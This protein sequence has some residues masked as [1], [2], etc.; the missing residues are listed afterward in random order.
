MDDNFLED[1]FDLSNLRYSSADKVNEFVNHINSIDI[2]VLTS[3]NLIIII[4][5]G[6]TISMKIEN[7]VSIPDLDCEKIIEVGVSHLRDKF[8]VESFELFS[9]DSSQM[10][11]S[12]ISEIAIV[13]SY[14][15]SK[16]NS[17]IFL[18]FVLFHGTDTMSYS[19][20]ALSLILGRGL[21]FSVVYTGAQKPMQEPMSDAVNNVRNS[22]YMLESL[23]NYNRAEVVIVMGRIAVLGSSSTKIDDEKIDAFTSPMHKYV[24]KFDKLEYP[25]VLADWLNERRD[26]DFHPLIWNDKYGH[27]L[28]VQSVLGLDP[29]VIMQQMDNNK[30]KAVILYSYGAST[31][32]KKL[33]DK[34]IIKADNINVP[35]F[36]VN[37]T[38]AEPKPT[39][40]SGKE[41]LD[42]GVIPLFMT[43]PACLAK[44][45]IAWRKYKNDIEKISEFMIES[46]VG[47]VPSEQSKYIEKR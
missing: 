1:P 19:S 34:I 16:I 33:I 29:E 41:M 40:L 22:F 46:Y 28:L 9:L 8:T 10:N 23:K 36:V 44:I 11:Y 20:A 32:Y 2:D 26:E 7:G 37:P 42:K 4:G 12:H 5:T 18:G 6:G 14:I 30:I 13:I 47:E 3:K 35:V 27:S 39:Y 15:Y 45:E 25:V 43:L 17:D 24:A 38:N 21:P 31:V